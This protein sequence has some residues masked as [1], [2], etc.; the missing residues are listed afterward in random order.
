[1]KYF[2][3]IIFLS[4]SILFFTCKK[5]QSNEFKLRGV[6]RDATNG[7][8]IENVEITVGQ[9]EVGSGT[10]N[11]NFVEVASSVT[12]AQGIYECDWE[13]RNIVSVEVKAE[14]AQWIPSSVELNASKFQPGVTV[15]Q[16]L[17]LY[18]EALINIQIN[19]TT[20][21][22]TN[23]NFRFENAFFDCNCC[24]NEWKNFNSNEGDSTFSCRAYGDSWL[25]Y[26]YELT[27]SGQDSLVQDSLFL[28]RF[29]NSS[30]VINW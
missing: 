2:Q 12:S 19:R 4:L 27:A 22:W 21:D 30:L 29:T 6:V 23:L 14:K 13:K 18:P 9:Q 11:G 25:K 20:N 10:F 5:E 16:D 8:A 1:M 24:N 15:Y 26:R 7:S 28:E 17:S 3:V